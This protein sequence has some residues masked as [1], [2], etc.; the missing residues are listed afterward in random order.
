MAAYRGRC[1]ISGCAVSAIL[2]AAHIVPYLG[3]HTNHVQ[4]GILLRADIHSLFD[5]GLI[6]IAPD[7]YSVTL[8]PELIGSEYAAL[9]GQ[10]LSLPADKNF[11]P[12]TDALRQ[13]PWPIGLGPLRR[14]PSSHAAH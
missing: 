13:R 12:S 6:T 3:D 14:G 2:E 11:C 10:R 5:L 8:A 1:A 7:T 4:N 9:E